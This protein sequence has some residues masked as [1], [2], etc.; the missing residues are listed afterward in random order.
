MNT[1]YITTSIAYTNAPPHVGFALELIQ[2]DVLARLHRLRGEKVFFLTGTDE[3]GSKIA[4]AARAAGQDPQEFV[5]GVSRRFQELAEQLNISNDDFI[6][7][8]DKRRHWPSVEKMWGRLRERGD[9]Y[10]KEYEG[11][12]CAGCEAFVTEKEL[13]DGLCPVHK[14]EPELVREE[15]Y[16]FR[17]SRYGEKIAEALR[18]G[19]MRIVPGHRANE[20]LSFIEQGL[21][22]ISV[23]RS[24]KTL[25]WG[26]PIPGDENQIFYVWLDALTNYISALHYAEEGEMFK[27]FWPADVHCIGKDILRFHA[28]IWPAMLLSAGVELPRTIFAHGFLTVEG[29][30]MSKSLGNVVD[31]FEL[32]KTYGTDAVRYF[33]LREIPPAED[34]D[35]SHE[36]MGARI[37]ADLAGGI[38]NLL[39]RVLAVAEKAGASLSDRPIEHDGL[40]E[41]AEGVEEKVASLL[42]SFQFSSALEEVWKLESFCDRLIEQ[43]RPWENPNEKKKMLEDLLSALYRISRMLDPFLPETAERMRSQLEGREPRTSL[44]ARV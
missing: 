21:E 3:H 24:T 8:T 27:T 2:A 5:N 9:I 20:V 31:P 23:S 40:R 10:K 12:Y 30:K 7:T 11:L 38:G 42:D 29:Q 39:S 13:I 28:V 35:F 19:A 44:F 26:I 6:R 43:E 41:A 18:N 14:K 36:K 33:F 1:F 32:A 16:F 4:R 25:S 34:G 17:L 37:N 22:D 15:N